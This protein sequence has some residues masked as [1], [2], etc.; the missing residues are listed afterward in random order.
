MGELIL[1]PLER[2][3]GHKPGRLVMDRIGSIWQQA[4]RHVLEGQIGCQQLEVALVNETD[5]AFLSCA[6]AKPFSPNGTR[7]HSPPS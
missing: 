5:F 6:A 2:R 1:F 7:S 3:R 4:K